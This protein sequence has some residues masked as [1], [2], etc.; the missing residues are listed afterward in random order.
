MIVVPA[1]LPPW[2]SRDA[3]G[4]EAERTSSPA[5]VGEIRGPAFWDA[6][7]EDYPEVVRSSPLIERGTRRFP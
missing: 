4:W 2:D 6:E 5:Q 3:E 7:L 1:L